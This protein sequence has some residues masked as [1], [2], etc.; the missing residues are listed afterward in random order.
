V[1]EAQD[2]SA[3]R[4][5]AQVATTTGRVHDRPDE[6]QVNKED[7][8]AQRIGPASGSTL[9]RS[10]DVRAMDVATAP[11]IVPLAAH[12]SGRGARGE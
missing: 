7:C 3:R 5:T 2:P 12:S 11:L 9:G 4:P 6:I 8:A 10:N 1:T